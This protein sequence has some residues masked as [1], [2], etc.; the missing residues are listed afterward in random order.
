MHHGCE[1]RRTHNWQN[2]EPTRR[3]RREDVG[4]HV[5]ALGRRRNIR[6][7]VSDFY[8]DNYEGLEYEGFKRP[9]PSTSEELSVSD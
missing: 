3:R 2:E 6:P 4:V 9:C 7:I 1:Y 8:R 5:R